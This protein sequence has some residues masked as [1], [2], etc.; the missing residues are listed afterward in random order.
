MGKD[1]GLV[2]KLNDDEGEIVGDDEGFD[3]SEVEDGEIVGAIV[4]E[5]D[6]EGKKLEVIGS[7]EGKTDGIVVIVGENDSWEG[8]KFSEGAEGL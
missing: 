5:S 4:D 7:S 1:E 3:I 8:V 6:F 2:D